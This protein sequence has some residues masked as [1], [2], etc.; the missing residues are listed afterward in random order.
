MYTSAHCFSIVNT[1]EVIVI[2]GGHAGCEAAL[3]SARRGL[4]TLLLTQNLD[5]IAQLSCNPA[6][7]GI[8]KSH[9]LR[10]VDALGGAM[11]RVT[12]AV[13]IHFRVLNASR[14]PS[15]RG[16]RAQVDRMLY[17]Q[18]MRRVIDSQ[19]GLDVFQQTV[20]DLIVEGGRVAGVVT[21]QSIHIR[22]QAVVLTTG[23]F[24]AG[25]IHVGVESYPGGRAGEAPSNRLAQRL[26][27][28]NLDIGR[29]K[30]GTPPRLDARSLDFSVMRPQPG[31]DPA[32]RISFLPLDRQP[33]EQ[34]LCHITETNPRTHQ[35]VRDNL[36]KSPMYAG[37]IDGIGPRYCPSLEDKVARFGD[38]DSHLIF[39]EPEGVDSIEVYPNGISTSLPYTVQEEF[40][41]SIRGFERARIVRPGYAIEYDFINPISL[42]QTLES[43][44]V[45][46][47]FLAGQINGTTGY[48]EAGAQ[49]LIAGL[50]ASRLVRGEPGWVPGRNQAYT[51][52]MVDDLSTRGVRE[53]Y[54]M[55]TSRAEYRL[56][57]RE[58]NADRRLTAIGRELGLVS[59][60]RWR[61]FSEKRDNIERQREQLAATRVRPKTLP[62][63]FTEDDNGRT[64]EELMRRPAVG[65]RDLCA[66]LEV[67]TDNAEVIEQL[68]TDISYA[69]YIDRQ[70]REI[71]RNR[72][73]EAI[74]LPQ[75]L[76]YG[77]VSGLSNE[78]AQ[79]LGEIRPTT[80][81]QAARV[82][83]V[84]PASISL[85]RVY[86]KKHRAAIVG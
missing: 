40:V 49:G 58:D 7:G 71:E 84:T 74:R 78:A 21:A 14:G 12:D 31:A 29:L 72:D 65:Y 18:Q 8:G 33:L 32:P 23:T 57:L 24:L 85:L 9:L 83:G 35:V 52:V 56:L 55:F 5:V 86:L 82:Q 62:D 22:A 77:E 60:R 70:Q 34:H 11:A 13:G 75:H 81:G 41:R 48:E 66:W 17:R 44:H 4:Q 61:I 79:C 19:Q 20:D 45:S 50:N 64:F 10:E 54:R 28:L 26:R 2:G 53:P 68:E 27:D 63:G 16:T 43:R 3:A 67:P 42:H 36:A 76:D 69:G 47:L 46:G 30:T 39:V 1:Y 25:R 15:V 51:G 37:K 80:L 6:M 73:N 59:D 38:R